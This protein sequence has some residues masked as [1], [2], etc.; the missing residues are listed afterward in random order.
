MGKELATYPSK[1]SPGKHYTIYEPNNGGEPYCDCW[2][3][4]RKRT[5]SHLKAYAAEQAGNIP[6]A[7]VKPKYTEG[8]FDSEIADAVRNIIN[9][10]A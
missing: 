5:C 7:P 4:K 3:W 9:K 8:T 1:S 2:Q 6:T 10:S